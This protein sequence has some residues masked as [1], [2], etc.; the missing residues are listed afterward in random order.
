MLTDFNNAMVI[1][2]KAEK[3]RNFVFKGYLFFIKICF[4]FL[5]YDSIISSHV[6]VE[7]SIILA[8]YFAFSQLHVEGFKV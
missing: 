5:V 6:I 8:K 1:N 4:C 3:Y 2:K 7:L